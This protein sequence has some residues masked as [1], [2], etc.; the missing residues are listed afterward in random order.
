MVPFYST[1][2]LSKVSKDNVSGRTTPLTN[3]YATI[4]RKLYSVLLILVSR[5]T[6]GLT[7]VEVGVGGDEHAVR[8]EVRV[9]RW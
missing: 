1:E 9:A 3:S 6:T 7:L 2:S 4:S 8:V 5:P